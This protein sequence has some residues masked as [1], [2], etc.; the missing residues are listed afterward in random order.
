M[1]DAVRPGKGRR[2]HYF[3]AAAAGPLPPHFQVAD[4]AE[5]PNAGASALDTVGD[6]ELHVRIEL[7]RARMAWQ[8]ALDLRSGAVVPL[9]KL[10]DDLVD[11][12]AGGRLVARGEV[13]VLDDKF[14]VRVVELVSADGA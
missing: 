3:D 2:D 13:V 6:V 7:G 4:L 9:D 10:A 14:C 5:R 8:A 1:T 12:V 11:V